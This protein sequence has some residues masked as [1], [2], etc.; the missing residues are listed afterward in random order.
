[1]ASIRSTRSIKLS[2]K[3]TEIMKASKLLLPLPTNTINSTKIMD[4]PNISVSKPD[5]TT[6]PRTQ[7]I[8]SETNQ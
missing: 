5:S 2:K 1:M 3:N 4:I 7:Q 8:S 6:V